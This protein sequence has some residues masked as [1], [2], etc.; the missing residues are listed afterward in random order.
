MSQLLSDDGV[1]Y[2]NFGTSISKDASTIVVGANFANFHRMITDSGAA[3]Y[4][5]IGDD[6]DNDNGIYTNGK[7]CG[8]RSRN[9]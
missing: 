6:D 7:I 1:E 3:Q 4:D 2:D 9:R 8:R 5:N